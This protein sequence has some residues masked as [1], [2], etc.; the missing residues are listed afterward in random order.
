MDQETGV[1]VR[2]K[3][4]LCITCKPYE[5]GQFVVKIVTND[6]VRAFD[7]YVDREATSK[8][9]LCD[10]VTKGDSCFTTGDLVEMDKYGYIYFKDRIG[11]TFRWKSENVSTMEVENVIMS[12]LGLA[13]V[14]VFGVIVPGCE[15]RAGMAAI[16]AEGNLD[17]ASLLATLADTLPSFAMPVFIRIVRSVDLTGTFKFNKVALKRDGFD[18]EATSD[19]VFFLERRVKPSAYTKLTLSLYED[20]LNGQIRF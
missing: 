20:I 14:V 3:N 9:V 7:G 17:L 13:D 16:Q 19:P 5:V 12:A 11:D 6:P 1:P 2:D 18:P 4:G 8:K 15:G 10:V